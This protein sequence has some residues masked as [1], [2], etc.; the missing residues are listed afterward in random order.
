ME[1]WIEF[2]S[3]PSLRMSIQPRRYY[4]RR[5]AAEA[6]FCSIPKAVC[7]NPKLR[8]AADAAGIT[9]DD[10]QRNGGGVIDNLRRD[11]VM[12][13]CDPKLALG[14]LMRS[15]R[16]TPIGSQGDAI[17]KTCRSKRAY[18]FLIC[19]RTLSNSALAARAARSAS[20]AATSAKVHC[21]ATSGSLPSPP[22]CLT[23][24]SPAGSPIER[25]TAEALRRTSRTSA[26]KPG[27]A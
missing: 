15:P 4:T 23:N 27:L 6:K 2:P 1:S 12:F 10:A 13:A 9:T 26:A 18:S 22:E 19:T 14:R 11:G 17:A 8:K 16:R 20:R 24:I 25:R 5:S 3:D 21:Q 7:R